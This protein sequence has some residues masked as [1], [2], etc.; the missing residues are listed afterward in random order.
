MK[1]DKDNFYIATPVHD[2][3]RKANY[4]VMDQ[5]DPGHFTRCEVKCGEALSQDISTR[6]KLNLVPNGRLYWRLRDGV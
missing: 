4:L 6:L 1:S 3:G 5:E 2:D